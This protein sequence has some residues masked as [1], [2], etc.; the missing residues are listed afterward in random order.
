MIEDYGL[1]LMLGEIAPSQKLADEWRVRVRNESL[2]SV[3]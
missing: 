2:M 3:N 1:L